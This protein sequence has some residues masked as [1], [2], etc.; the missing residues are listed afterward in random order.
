MSIYIEIISKL[1][2]EDNTDNKE[3]KLEK[4]NETEKQFNLV[5]SH[6]ICVIYSEEL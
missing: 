1:N 5:L 4:Q 6:Q 2:I 3:N